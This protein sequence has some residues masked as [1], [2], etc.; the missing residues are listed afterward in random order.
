MQTNTTTPELRVTFST[1]T[2]DV[3]LSVVDSV[4]S[5]P[6]IAIGASSITLKDNQN[7]STVIISA[8]SKTQ[9]SN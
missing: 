9:T 4:D 1:F 5:N 3:I 7:N 8:N 2:K 6:N